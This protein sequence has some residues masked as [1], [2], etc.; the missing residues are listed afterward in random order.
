MPVSSRIVSP[1]A[2]QATVMAS[3]VCTSLGRGRE[4]SGVE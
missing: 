4:S 1:G 3:P 2:G